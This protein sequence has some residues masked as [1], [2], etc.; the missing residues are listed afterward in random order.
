M[1]T[2]TCTGEYLPVAASVSGSS[3]GYTPGGNPALPVSRREQLQE[4]MMARSFVGALAF[5]RVDMASELVLAQETW[6]VTPSMGIPFPQP[7]SKTWNPPIQ[8]R[9]MREDK[10]ELSSLPQREP[11]LLRYHDQCSRVQPNL[12]LRFC[13]Q[14]LVNDLLRCRGWFPEIAEPL[15]QQLPLFPFLRMLPTETENS[16]CH[17]FQK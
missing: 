12:T 11:T 1:E 10:W 3:L 17:V 8:V 5:D 15:T 9:V 14:T 13:V 4:R 2:P 6:R 16:G 7:E